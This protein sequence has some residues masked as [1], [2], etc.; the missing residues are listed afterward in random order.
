MSL[1]KL[2]SLL[3]DL[4]K[5]IVSDAAKDTRRDFFDGAIRP[6]YEGLDSIRKEYV[7]L[8]HTL[9]K[10]IN[11]SSSIANFQSAVQEFKEGRDDIV[12]RRGRY[13]FNRMN[14]NLLT[15]FGMVKQSLIKHESDYAEKKEIVQSIEAFCDSVSI[16][17]TGNPLVHPPGTRAARMRDALEEALHQLEGGNYPRFIEVA[18]RD[19]NGI[20]KTIDM[21]IDNMNEAWTIVEQDYDKLSI[22]FGRFKYSSAEKDLEQRKSE[23]NS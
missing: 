19:P 22:L 23:K 12:S 5:T 11:E 16:Y 20:A 9:R 10:R 13:F 2:H 4:L 15:R 3:L 21:E 14:N 1:S 17:F 7:K 6:L 8:F 18:I